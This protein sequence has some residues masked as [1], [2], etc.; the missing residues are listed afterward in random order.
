MPTLWTRTDNSLHFLLSET[1]WHQVN[2]LSNSVLEQFGAGSSYH[3]SFAHCWRRGPR[4]DLSQDFKKMQKLKKLPEG[5][6]LWL[7]F[8]TKNLFSKIINVFHPVFTPIGRVLFKNIIIFFFEH[9]FMHLWK[10]QHPNILFLLKFR[11]SWRIWEP[12]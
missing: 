4:L 9:I 1:C 11:C 10:P 2:D 3:T 6:F 5:P 8:Y 7:L 12:N